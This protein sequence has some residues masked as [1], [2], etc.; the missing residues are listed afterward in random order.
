MCTI[1]CL[2]KASSPESFL[3][4]PLVSL[5]NKPVFP[6]LST[7]GDCLLLF[8]LLGELGVLKGT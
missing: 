1:L 8:G 7:H 4:L 6:Y 2:I 5:G 3:D